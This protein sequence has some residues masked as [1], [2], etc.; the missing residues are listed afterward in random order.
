MLFASQ[1]DVGLHR[2]AEG[3]DVAI[4]VFKGKHIVALRKRIE[5]GIVL[6]VLLRHVPI[7]GLA[8]AL[9]G[10]EKILRKGVGFVPCVGRIFVR[11][12][13]LLLPG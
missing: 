12:R 7:K 11:T 3:V 6:E 1:R 10:Q 9:V 13:T 5:I 4:S 2:R 8:T